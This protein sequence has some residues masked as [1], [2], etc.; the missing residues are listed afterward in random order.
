MCAEERSEQHVAGRLRCSR[1]SRLL[2][3]PDALPVHTAWPSCGLC[4]SQK[5]RVSLQRGLNWGPACC[6]MS[7]EPTEGSL[8]LTTPPEEYGLFL[9]CRGAHSPSCRHLVM[10]NK[11]LDSTA[12]RQRRRCLI[13]PPLLKALSRG[14]VGQGHV[15]LGFE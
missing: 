13:Q 8:Q 12:G 15:Q 11:L 10:L 14:Q 1:K 2:N 6:C 5:V 3:R 7:A 9:Y 4:R